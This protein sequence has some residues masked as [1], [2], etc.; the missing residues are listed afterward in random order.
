MTLPGSRGAV[1]DGIAVLTPIIMPITDM[2]E[3]THTH[4]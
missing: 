3:G 2:L 4:D 1:A